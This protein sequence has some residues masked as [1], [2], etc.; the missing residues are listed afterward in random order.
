VSPGGGSCGRIAEAI[1]AALG[2]APSRT[3]RLSGGCVGDVYRIDLDDGER[4]VAKVDNAVGGQLDLEGKMLETLA[5]HLPVPGVIFAA[6]DLLLMEFVEGS[7]S[8]TPGAETHAAELV[9]ALHEVTA[10][11]YGFE[12]DSLIGGLSQSNVWTGSWLA[13]FAEHRLMAMARQCQDKGRIDDSMVRRVERLSGKLEEHLAEP[14]RPSLLHGD[15]WSG[16]VL[17]QGDR[18]TGF[19]DPAVSYGHPEIEL[20]FTTLFSSFG[21][22]FFDRYEELHPIPAGFHEER[23]HLYNLYPLLVHVCLFGGSYVNSVDQCLRRFGC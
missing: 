13:F 18:I 20:A 1:E 23:R 8:L 3:M 16:N 11:E 4:L 17:A 7:S 12:C 19:I 5:P 14:S 10:D 9:A 2:R 15:L 22:P 21:R 6:P